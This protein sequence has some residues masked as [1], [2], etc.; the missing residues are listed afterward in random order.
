MCLLVVMSR[1]DPDAPL[2]VAANRDEKLDRPAVSAT[3][4]GDCPRVLGGRDLM[5]GGTWLAVNEHGLVVGLTNRPSKEGRDDS[6]RSRGELPLVLAAHERAADAVEHFATSVRSEHYNQAWLLV[7]DRES[8]YHLAV[9]EEGPPVVEA[10]DPGVHVLANGPLQERSP[11]TDLVRQGIAAVATPGT[12]KSLAVLRAAL[13]DHTVPPGLA[14]EERPPDRPAQLAAACV[15]TESFGTRSAALIRVPAV[16]RPS[17]WVADGPPC[18][19]SF[20]SIDS[21][22][23]R[24]PA[25]TPA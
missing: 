1:M 11:K 20:A 6:K 10:L 21:L 24:D 16:G 12:D 8:L 18:Q 2:V 14:A 17:A 4:L 5:A 7:G 19:A 15:H 25:G 3:V 9:G 23:T 22:W 13:A